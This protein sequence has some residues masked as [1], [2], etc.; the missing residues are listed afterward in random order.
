MVAWKIRTVRIASSALM[1]TASLHGSNH[2]LATMYSSHTRRLFWIILDAL[3]P[4]DA[5]TYLLSHPV[6]LV[7]ITTA[8]FSP[9]PRPWE[10]GAALR[11]VL[12]RAL[13]HHSVQAFPGL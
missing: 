4:D 12:S 13:Y 8:G 11:L 10:R 9:W 7:E 1:S 6:I 2:R 3:Y 5:E